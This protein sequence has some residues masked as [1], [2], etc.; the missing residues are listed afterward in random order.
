MIT[1]VVITGVDAVKKQLEK[2]ALEEK[3]ALK[4]ALTLSANL[5][6][7]DAIKSIKE[8]SHGDK[9]VKRGKKWHTISK[10]GDAPNKDTGRLMNSI[11]ISVHDTYAEVKT[12]VKY[13]AALEKGSKKMGVRPFLEPALEKNRKKI[14]DIFGKEISL[15]VVID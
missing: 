6:K 7:N 12:N 8:V 2:V 10:E 9:K 3:K 11:S 5:I 14:N 13:A 1:K 4:K 15:A